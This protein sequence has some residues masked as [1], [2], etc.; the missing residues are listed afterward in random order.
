MF[1]ARNLGIIALAVLGLAAAPAARAQ[2]TITVFV[3]NFDFQNANTGG[4][5]FDPTIK[6]GD[7]IDWVWSTANGAVSHSTT[8][9]VSAH[10]PENWD[11]GV[12][13]TGNPP[14]SFTHTFSH[15]GIYPY[16]CTVHGLDNGNGTASG[17][18]GK[19]IVVPAPGALITA[20][21]GAVPGVS[22]ALRRRRRR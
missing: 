19:I 12:H 16:I 4:S 22:L 6:T 11:S 8:S 2:N 14:F 18:S 13:M 5:H 20:L 1:R 17:M 3:T 10:L 15:T 9:L 21:I 7:T